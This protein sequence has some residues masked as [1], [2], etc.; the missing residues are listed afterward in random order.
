LKNLL[1]DSYQQS[2][3]LFLFGVVG[4]LVLY[5][6]NQQAE[7]ILSQRF[8]LE[9]HDQLR[10]QRLVYRG[11]RSFNR[12]DKSAVVAALRVGDLLKRVQEGQVPIAVRLILPFVL[13]RR[14]RI[15]QAA[16]AQLHLLFDPSNG[17]ELL[18]VDLE[19]EALV[20]Q[21]LVEVLLLDI[22]P[23]RGCKLLPALHHFLLF[24]LELLLQV[25]DRLARVFLQAA[26][27]A[28]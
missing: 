7:D 19:I 27:Q 5:M 28:A 21:R 4:A 13:L 23:G 26:Q 3:Q 24:Q 15:N 12:T 17:G 16:A 1:H 18:V 10:D 14:L 11:A 9:D 22:E 25:G 6:V 8:V 2:A 20:V